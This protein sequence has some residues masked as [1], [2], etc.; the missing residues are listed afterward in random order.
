[1]WKLNNHSWKKYKIYFLCKKRTLRLVV[2]H[3]LEKL[4]FFE[5]KTFFDFYLL[6][7]FLKTK[8][9]QL[10]CVDRFQN[11]VWSFL[12]FKWVWR[13][14]TFGDFTAPKIV[15]HKK[16]HIL[17]CKI[18]ERLDWTLESSSSYSKHCL[19]IFLD[20]CVSWGFISYFNSWCDSS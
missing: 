8:Y 19:S 3:T 18:S 17:Y 9:S 12:K 13:Y 6:F 20:E 7:F 1:M 4:Q 10:I 16:S 11:S 15:L 2:F 14:L 5:K